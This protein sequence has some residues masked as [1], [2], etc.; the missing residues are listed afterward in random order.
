MTQAT[1]IIIG[2]NS[3]SA[4]FPFN[5]AQRAATFLKNTWNDLT[6]NKSSLFSK[7]LRENQLTEN[8]HFYLNRL[9]GSD[10][11]L[12]GL[13]INEDSHLDL[14]N[15][16]STNPKP[17]KRIRKD[18]TYF[19]NIS[20]FR[21]ALIFEFKKIS[22]S[23]GSW[24]E[25]TNQNGMRRFVD[26]TYARNQ[27]HALMV[28]IIMEQQ[29]STI[30]IQGIQKSLLKPKTRDSLCMVQTQ[31]SWLC[32]PSKV[33]PGVAEFDTEHRRPEQEAPEKGTISLSHLFITL[34]T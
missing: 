21:M 9:S 5:E 19:S 33:F 7:N 20:G 29:Y 14:D 3:W 31:N 8:L 25:Y 22:I 32:N 26:G 27:P 23:R 10:G 12:M 15:P 2:N 17:G 18:I 34:P 6:V 4:V 28:G 30:C 13:W 24:R 11:L 1:S 16:D